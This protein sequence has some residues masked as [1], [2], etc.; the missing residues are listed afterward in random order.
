MTYQNHSPA[1]GKQE[2]LTVPAWPEQVFQAQE[3]RESPGQNLP[4]SI[5]VCLPHAT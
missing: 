3:A 5:P 4:D 1:L 2:L